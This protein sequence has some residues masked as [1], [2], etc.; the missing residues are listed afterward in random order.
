MRNQKRLKSFISHLKKQSD[1]QNWMRLFAAFERC[2]IDAKI[3]RI[4][5][6]EDK[7]VHRGASIIL[8][9]FDFFDFIFLCEN[10]LSLCKFI[11]IYA[12]YFKLTLPD[13]IIVNPPEGRKSFFIIWSKRK[14][15]FSEEK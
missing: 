13:F 11:E 1:A 6:H 14:A 2:A 7:T 8:E 5:I 15:C 3:S 12:K 10:Y 4:F 9:S